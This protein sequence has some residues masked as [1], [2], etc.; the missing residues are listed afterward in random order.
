MRL[1]VILL[2]PEEEALVNQVKFLV[3]IFLELALELEP[4]LL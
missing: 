4:K 2:C 1:C 3:R